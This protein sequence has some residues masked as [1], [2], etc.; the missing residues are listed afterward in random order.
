MEKTSKN[1]WKNFKKTLR[2]RMQK[3]LQW[4]TKAHHYGVLA[5]DITRLERTGEWGQVRSKQ[6]K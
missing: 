2:W 3:K 5:F 1:K 6:N 4:N